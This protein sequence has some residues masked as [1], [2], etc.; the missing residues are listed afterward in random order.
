MKNTASV[1]VLLVFMSA[2][3]GREDPPAPGEMIRDCAHC[4]EMVLV[5][6]G[7]FRMGSQRGAPDEM[8]VRRVTLRRDFMVARYEATF[9]EWDECVRDG[10]C[11][12]RPRDVGWGRGTRPVINVSW[13]DLQGYLVWLREKSG[14]HYRL[15]SEAEWEYAARAG[16]AD[17][18]PWGD[19]PGSG[20]ANCDRCGSRW[21]NQSTS[22][23][24]SFAANRFGLHD[25][26]GNV[27]EW[28]EDCW[29][30]NYRGAPADG[31]S[32]AAG[33]CSRRVLRGGSFSNTPDVVRPSHRLENLTSVRLISAGFR[34]ARD[35]D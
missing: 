25:M 30:P 34:V 15:L 19:A 13:D 12:Y 31:H 32:L 10:G 16:S 26:L 6:A 5:P 24:G 9:S 4:P 20:R 3:H 23:A 18:Y 22:P 11:S 29:N 33:D 2:V 35:I 7:S 8:P 17:R 21:D 1:V 28:V 14:K 27:W